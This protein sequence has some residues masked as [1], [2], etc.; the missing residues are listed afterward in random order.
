M[1]ECLGGDLYTHT[2][3]NVKQIRGT[4]T[5][6]EG[7]VV[8]WNVANGGSVGDAH[9]RRDPGQ[10]PSQWN[11]GDYVEIISLDGLCEEDPCTSAPTHISYVSFSLVF[12]THTHTHTHTET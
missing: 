5:I 6:W 12:H 9:G 11:V 7:R 4:S 10:S 2:F 8:M 1:E 3:Y